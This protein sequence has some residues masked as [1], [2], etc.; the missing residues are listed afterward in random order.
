VTWEAGDVRVGYRGLI[1]PPVASGHWTAADW[2]A[3][4]AA[5]HLVMPIR[6]VRP[7]VC[8]LCYRP[9]AADAGTAGGGWCANC[10]SVVREQLT[11]LVPISY[12]HAGGLESPLRAYKSHGPQHRWLVAPL[13][14]LLGAFLDR[15]GRCIRSRLGPIDAC[16]TVPYHHPGNG[17]DFRPLVELVQH[18]SAWPHGQP[19]RL[20]LVRKTR[21]GKLAKQALDPDAFQAT[22]D[23]TG[24][25]VLVIDD[26]FTSGTTL[27]SVASA[28]RRAG[29]D[30][31]VGLTLGRQLNPAWHAESA[32]VL[33]EQWERRFDL[34]WCVLE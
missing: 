25:G 7:P 26:T 4:L 9:V 21:P 22:A 3:W 6:G 12:S 24:A 11:G 27:A 10:V 28:L 30:R 34:D 20:D 1:T 14:A 33:A 15:H 5:E 32:P 18:S 29:A 8:R 17:R 2:V 23:L 16:C 31:V 13:A 19:W